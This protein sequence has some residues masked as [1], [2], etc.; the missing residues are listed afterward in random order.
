[1]PKNGDVVANFLAM[2]QYTGVAPDE[3]LE[4]NW[5][6]ETFS[7]G[8]YVV[9]DRKLDAIVVSI[10]GTWSIIDSVAD[11]LAKGVPFAFRG[12]SGYAHEGVLRCAEKKYAALLPLFNDLDGTRRLI[13]TGHSLGGGVAILLA[14]MVAERHPELRVSCTAF[15]PAPSLTLPLATHPL[16]R[17]FVT[18]F[19]LQ[20]DAVPRLSLG[21]MARTKA[22]VQ[23]LLLQ[24]GSTKERLMQCAAGGNVLRSYTKSKLGVRS[25]VDIV[26]AMNAARAST[27][28][29]D[30]NTFMYPAGRVFYLSVE[31]NGSDTDDDD[32]SSSSS[33]S[34][35]GSSSSD[36]DSDWNSSSSDSDSGSES[37]DS[38]ESY[39]KLGDE[40]GG[41][42]E[43]G[44]STDEEALMK[45]IHKGEFYESDGAAV[46]LS[47]GILRPILSDKE[48]ER[49]MR[50]EEE[51]ERKRR[52][53]RKEKRKK[54]K[55]EER[56]KR[57]ER[58]RKRKLRS[59]ED[60]KT[61]WKWGVPR[62]HM[63]CSIAEICAD[64]M[65]YFR[66]L[67]FSKRFWFD[68]MIFRYEEGLC[69]A[70]TKITGVPH[71]MS[72]PIKI[73]TL[74]KRVSEEPTEMALIVDKS[75]SYES[76]HPP[77]AIT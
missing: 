30:D 76:D 53:E 52:K 28:D 5:E 56:K 59:N 35:S 45:M 38:K 51:E 27:S 65:D 61:L 32:D 18:S 41:L 62:E 1:M 68:H 33:S 37:S 7:T 42:W 2:C 64:S 39:D 8:H 23:N 57:K 66:E 6:S 26:T 34:K 10:R 31:N 55:E 21:S 50:K 9:Y 13:F 75:T 29:A 47:P 70:L 43:L 20:D 77:P 72:T 17:K 44:K 15:A 54:E 74:V 49:R 12:V 24:G 3:V 73:E 58:E 16:V 36:S 67:V 25:K 4:T 14:M 22:I 19:A 63:Q 60:W 69:S 11:L 46:Q 48:M 40:A 71:Q